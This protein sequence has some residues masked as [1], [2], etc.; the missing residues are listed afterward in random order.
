MYN[1]YIQLA[2][3]GHQCTIDWTRGW[4]NCLASLIMLEYSTAMIFVVPNVNNF[5]SWAPASRF[6]LTHQCV[7]GAKGKNRRVTQCREFFKNDALSGNTTKYVR[8]S[9]HLKRSLCNPVP[10]LQPP[11]FRLLSP[12]S[13]LPSLV[14]PLRAIPS[15]PLKHQLTGVGVKMNAS[16]RDGR[17]LLGGEGWV[18][19]LAVWTKVT[20]YVW[21]QP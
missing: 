17:W 15:L 5:Q 21:T 14:S 13:Y 8:N 11:V 1:V 4:C 16:R 3:E 7:I 10:H 6:A 12:F 9:Q 18:W 19:P 2:A 20:Q